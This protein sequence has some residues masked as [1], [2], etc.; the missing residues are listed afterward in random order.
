MGM[1][2]EGTVEVGD[3]H[4][5]LQPD[6]LRAGDHHL[7]DPAVAEVEYALQQLRLHPLHYALCRADVD[8]HAQLALGHGG[9]LPR[10]PAQEQTREQ[11]GHEGDHRQE[12]REHLHGGVNQPAHGEG[13]PLGGAD[14]EDFGGHLAE[15]HGAD[16]EEDRG[17]CDPP[18]QLSH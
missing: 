11:I 16:G 3:S 5:R 17:H 12:R 13:V 18:A 15:D 4:A 8:E 10:P 7:V 1:L 9:H 2:R 14:G 6:H